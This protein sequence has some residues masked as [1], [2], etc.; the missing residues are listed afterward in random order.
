MIYRTSLN[1]GHDGST[2][3][4]VH[5]LMGWATLAS[6]KERAISKLKLTIPDY[7]RWLRSKGERV[8]AVRNPQIMIIEE[9][10]TR[11]SAGEAGGS[12]PL[13]SCDRIKCAHADISRCLQLLNY[14]RADFRQDHIQDSHRRIGLETS[15]RTPERTKRSGAYRPSRHLVSVPDT[16]GSTPRTEQ[17][18]EC[19]RI[20]RLRPFPR[21]R[22]P[23]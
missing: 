11:G 19:L 5:D 12:D 21:I 10:R 1:I 16:R 22:G 3:A 23:T 9:I 7:Y 17:N 13:F 8:P 18:E 6:T 2:S 20:S 14:T 15:V 4:H